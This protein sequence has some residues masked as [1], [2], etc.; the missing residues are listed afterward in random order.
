MCDSVPGAALAGFGPRC[1]CSL[2]PDSRPAPLVMFSSPEN[3]F[4]AGV[5]FPKAQARFA[6]E[7]APARSEPRNF[8]RA[9]PSLWAM[10][11]SVSR[12][13]LEDPP[14]PLAIIGVRHA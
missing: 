10:E 9:A 13:L 12:R 8:A 14:A 4:R 1:V 11:R 5:H 2:M 3:F 6:R 7:S